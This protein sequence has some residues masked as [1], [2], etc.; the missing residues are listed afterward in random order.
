MFLFGVLLA[1]Q[2]AASGGFKRLVTASLEALTAPR[3][4]HWHAP[5]SD[6]GTGGR[7]RRRLSQAAAA[8]GGWWLL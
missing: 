5:A 3:R 2:L 1:W 7:G 4:R 6:S 8:D